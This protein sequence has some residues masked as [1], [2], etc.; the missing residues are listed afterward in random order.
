MIMDKKYFLGLD[1][2]TD[3]V[4]WAVTDENFKLLKLKGKTAWG[5]RIFD[6]ANAA[7]NRRSRR[8]MRRRMARRRYRI[9]LLNEYIFGKEIEKIDPSFFLRLHESNLYFEDKNKKAMIRHPLFIEK[10]KEK[11]FYKKYPTIFHLRLAQINDESDAFSDLRYLYLTIHHIIKKRGNFLSM[12]SFDENASINKELVAEVNDML[13]SFVVGEGDNDESFNMNLIDMT[14][15]DKIKEILFNSSDDLNK[16]DKQRK[17]KEL[18]EKGKDLFSDKNDAKRWNDLIDLFASVIVYGKK[19]YFNCD[20]D[21]KIT[22]DFSQNY[23]DIRSA[24]ESALGN[25]IVLLDLAKIIFDIAY[26]KEHKDF[27]KSMVDVFNQHRNDLKMFKTLVKIVDNDNANLYKAVFNR[28]GANYNLTNENRNKPETISYAKFIDNPSKYEYKKESGYIGFSLHCKDFLKWLENKTDNKDA[29]ELVNVIKSRIENSDFLKRIADM[30][31]SS[32]PHQLHEKELDIILKNA[33]KYFTFINEE[34][35]RK[36]KSIFLFRINYYEG[37]LNTSSVYSNVVKKNNENE[38]IFPWN[39]DDV[40]DATETKNKFIKKLINN[41]TYFKMKPVLPKSSILFNDFNILNKLNTIRINGSLISQNVKIELF[42]FINVNH[43]TSIKSIEKYLKTHYKVYKDDGVCISGIDTEG[44]NSD[45]VSPARPFLREVFDLNDKKVLNQIDDIIV[46]WLT[47]YVDD[48]ETGILEIKK[49][50]KLTP[51]QEKAIRRLTCRNWASISKEFLTEK[52][53]TKPDGTVYS[54]LEILRDEVV[55]LNQILD[56]PIYGDVRNRIKKQNDEDRGKMTKCDLID[57]ILDNTPPMMRRPAIQA[58][59]IA[60]EIKKINKKKNLSLIVIETNRKNEKSKKTG[61]GKRT[62]DR[63]KE[64]NKLIDT[65]INDA[66]NSIRE[67]G[68]HLKTELVKKIKDDAR[69]KSEAIYLYFKQ[70]GFDLYT[71]ERMTLDK[72]LNSDTYDVDHIVPRSIIKDDSLDNK[73]LV[74]KIS[75][76]NIKKDIYPIPERIRSE[77]YP[78]WKKLHDRKI[79]SNEKYNALIRVTPLTDEEKNAFVRRQINVVNYSN[80]VIRDIFNI[81]FP[82][83]KIIFQKSEHVTYIRNQYKITKVRELNDTHHAVDAY[84]NIISGSILSSYYNMRLIKAVENLDTKYTYNPDKIIEYH[85]NN[86]DKLLELVKNTCEK[87]DML[88]TFREKYPDDAFYNQNIIAKPERSGVNALVPVHEKSKLADT[89]KYGGYSGLSRSYFVTGI[90]S[91]GK[92]VMISVPILYMNI[93]DKEKLNSILCMLYTGKNNNITFNLGKNDKIFP[94]STF[95]LTN[96]K[97]KYLVAPRNDKAL[98]ITPINPLFLN[99]QL[100]Y[101]LKLSIKKLKEIENTVKNTEQSLSQISFPRGRKGEKFDVISVEMNIKLKNELLNDLN[102]N[103]REYS[104]TKENIKEIKGK[105]LNETFETLNLFEQVNAIIKSI[106]LFNR[107][108]GN[109]RLSMDSFINLNPTLVKTSV[110]GLFEK[111]IKL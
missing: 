41:C 54:I 15:I 35:I 6:A 9:Y 76:Q 66:D 7:K 47:I 105:Y 93:G 103:T 106:A 8:S 72:V 77:C 2:G 86:D 91:K 17:I 107:K 81:M 20:D 70:L 19:N 90:N 100:R 12:G 38:K 43:K 26:A 74:N 80:I 46:K 25:K 29:I 34:V 110:T 65:I 87:Q 98:T 95:E 84:L 52:I 73:V 22:V 101:Y 39:K 11:S 5:A 36:I 59:K 111:K 68:N 1:I 104:S 99:E 64:L 71:G 13:L 109:F 79:L 88:L 27:S 3:S 51:E 28:K 44:A 31:T 23:E 85:F 14:I 94:N 62:I 4:G 33:R 48:K 50:M 75:N 60:S 45:F 82:K 40:I 63:R 92:K 67:A 69:L 37:P 32:I 83:T 10:E 21:S 102:K 24:Y 55:E 49:A 78:L 89:N 16:R 96:S 97:E 30:S 18:F 56:N 42:N 61:N 53:V 57:E 108:D 58:L